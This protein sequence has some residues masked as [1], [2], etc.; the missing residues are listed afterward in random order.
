MNIPSRQADARLAERHA[1]NKL[2]AAYQTGPAKL[3][4]MKVTAWQRIVV[5]LRRLG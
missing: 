4:R 1:H 2:F 3:I 5:R